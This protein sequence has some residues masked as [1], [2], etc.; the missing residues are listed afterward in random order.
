MLFSV[1]GAAT[2]LVPLLIIGVVVAFIVAGLAGEESMG[3]E[4]RRGRWLPL[5]Y[6]YLATV[7]GLVIMLVGIIGAL[8]GLV[9]AIIPEA[10]NEVRFSIAEQP[11]LTPEGKEA[12]ELTGAEKDKVRAESI[13]RARLG[14]YFNALQGLVTAV[15]GAPVF[16]WH[17][18]QARRKEPEWMT[19]VPESP[20]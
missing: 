11:R 5:V 3:T 14:G 13:E 15:V 12:K 16:V 10:S 18:R 2:L 1:F 19:A 7:V 8:R 20:N 17:L 6:Y 4:P 9:Q